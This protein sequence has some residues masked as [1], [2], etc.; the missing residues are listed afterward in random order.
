MTP[1]FINIGVV[2]LVRDSILGQNGLSEQTCSY[3]LWRRKP[4][5]CLAGQKQTACSEQP[6]LVA[7]AFSDFLGIV[8]SDG[9]CV[10]KT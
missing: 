1:R 4:R 9:Q 8:G 3:E 2:H 5:L 10:V 6:P 7:E